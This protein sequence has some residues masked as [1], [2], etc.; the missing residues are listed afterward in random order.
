MEGL[1]F[2]GLIHLAI[3]VYALVQIFGSSEGTG[4]KILWTVIV[5]AFPVV[6]IIIWF[7]AGPGTPKK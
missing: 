3:V 6:G 7:F 2:F 4:G 5:A 1:G